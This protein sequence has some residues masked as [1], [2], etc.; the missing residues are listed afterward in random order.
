MLSDREKQVLDLML[1]GHTATKD[2]AFQMKLSP[3]TVEIYRGGLMHQKCLRPHPQSAD[4]LQRDV[5]SYFSIPC[6][7]A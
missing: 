6:W 5:S 7:I 2:I 3:R 1:A 4:E